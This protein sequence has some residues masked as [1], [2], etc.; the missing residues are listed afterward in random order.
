MRFVAKG[1][2]SARA[3]RVA[4]AGAIAISVPASSMAQVSTANQELAEEFAVLKEPVETLRISEG[5]D[6]HAARR[7]VADIAGRTGELEDSATVLGTSA[8]ASL[9]ESR[10]A[11]GL[12]VRVAAQSPD[13]L[14]PRPTPDPTPPPAPTPSPASDQKVLSV[15]Y[16]TPAAAEFQRQCANQALLSYPPEWTWEV[17]EGIRSQPRSAMRAMGLQ[18]KVEQYRGGKL[19][20]TYDRLGGINTSCRV[21]PARSDSP[22][23]PASAACGPFSAYGPPA[24]QRGDTF[25]VYPAVY[26]EAVYLGPVKAIGVTA[27]LQQ[28]AVTIAVPSTKGIFAGDGI[29]GPATHVPVATRVVSVASA[30][31]LT[32]DKPMLDTGSV[33]LN[34][35]RALND[36]TIEGV[37]REIN[38]VPTRPAIVYNDTFNG[39]QG[40]G[41]GMLYF[42]GQGGAGD[43]KN[44]TMRNIDL[45]VEKPPE[46]QSKWPAPHRGLIFAG[47]GLQGT[48]TFAQ[49]RIKGSVHINAGAG[50]NGLITG[51][52]GDPNGWHPRGITG[53]VILD[54]VE[55]GENGG[56]EGPAHNAY[57]GEGD[58]TLVVERSWLHDV[59]AG[60]LF[61]TRAPRNV[62]TGNYFQGG[63]PL[64]DR[65]QAEFVRLGH[66]VR[67]RGE[68]CRKHLHEDCVSRQQ[69]SRH[70]QRWAVRNL[71]TTPGLA[72]K[73]ARRDPQQYV[74]CARAG[75]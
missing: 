16:T 45:L 1:S 36:I 58:Y 13:P 55:M 51:N 12:E 18:P 50:G 14:P 53:T 57:F 27:Q 68:D 64:P 63:Q 3:R 29:T 41:K 7:Q 35:L 28:G 20:A 34:I 72:R 75:L 15:S 70:L 56:A 10:D 40:L 73:Q 2:A 6:L 47:P 59:A 37:T 46:G 17:P 24:W 23:M 11:F 49:M 32:V 65:G 69:L 61:K 74:R 31:Q 71:Q 43:I 62:F 25:R 30:T 21:G 54:R 67:R 48:T 19:I 39:D 8:D 60:H 52:P 66:A 33:N 22:G 4:L 9:N 26:T 44:F 38:G 42:Y 5:T